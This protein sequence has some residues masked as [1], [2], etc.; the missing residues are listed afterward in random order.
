[1]RQEIKTE[2]YTSP[3]VEVIEVKARQ[4]ICTSRSNASTENFDDDESFEW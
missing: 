2:L 3:E 1:M 4:V